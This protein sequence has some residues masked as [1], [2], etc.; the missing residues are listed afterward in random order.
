MYSSS[1]RQCF[2][3]ETPRLENFGQMQNILNVL[4]IDFNDVIMDVT[5][6]INDVEV[7]RQDG[8]H[9][10]TKHEFLLVVSS[11]HFIGLFSGHGSIGHAS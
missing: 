3:N 10:Y 6:L 1:I 2:E 4:T 8:Q 7:S 5:R 9:H 11:Y